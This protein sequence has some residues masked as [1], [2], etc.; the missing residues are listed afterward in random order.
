MTDE[1]RDPLNNENNTQPAVPEETAPAKPVV[2]PEETASAPETPAQ[3]PQPAS[4]PQPVQPQA[5]PQ[6]VPQPQA[7]TPSQP[8]RSS[9]YS[10]YVPPQMPDPQGNWGYQVPPQPPKKKK[11]GAVVGIIIGVLA[12]LVLLGVLIAGLN[13]NGTV[14]AP[15][16]DE[17]PDTEA[18]T[19]EAPDTSK[20]K[21]DNAPIAAETDED[22]NSA[23]VSPDYTGEVLTPA[24]LYKAN[25]GSVV[26][27]EAQYSNGKSMGSGFVVDDENGYILTN[28]HVVN[29]APKVSV[30]FENGD[31]YEAE[32]IGADEI[33]DVAVLKIQAQ[34]LRKVT[35]GNS[36]EIE[37]G[38]YVN[39]IGNPLGEL[40]FTLTRGI[41]SAVDRSINTGEYN[42]TTFQTDAAINS[43]NSGGPVFDERGAVIGIASAKY[44]A[45]GVEG[46]GFCIPINDAIAIA[47]D[48][49]EY[50][51]VKGRPNF[52]ITISTSNGYTISTD[53]FGRRRIVETVPGAVVEQIGKGS[54]AEKAGLKVGDIITKL[55]DKKVTTASGLLNAKTAYKAGDTVTLEVFRDDGYITLT[56]TLDEYKPD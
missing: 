14:T 50:G 54:C 23:I 13:K 51:Y 43:G 48:L 47:K 18:V 22:G 29:G 16:T 25:V 8:Q 20:T 24:Q 9:F 41:I 1:Y 6:P 34:G 37:V 19:T 27:V 3:A 7:Q 28:Q 42:I 32:I 44:A 36:D 46:L 15:D 40:T 21:N 10:G 35:I 52:G 55:G 5:Q 11:T 12:Y 45:S 4:A 31:S 26:Y 38:S 53:E 2:I 30:T 39:V 17:G 49:V 56:V 33:N